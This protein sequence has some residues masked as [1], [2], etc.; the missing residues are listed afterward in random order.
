ML[1]EVFI[2]DFFKIVNFTKHSVN[3]TEFSNLGYVN[4]LGFT[5]Q[6]RML[7]FLILVISHNFPKAVTSFARVIN[8]IIENEND[9]DAH[10]HT[11]GGWY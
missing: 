6:N 4:N 1:F 11:K 10:G 8:K 3:Y 9:V 7:Y 2:E 5:R